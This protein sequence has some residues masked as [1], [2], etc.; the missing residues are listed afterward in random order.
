MPDKAK[1][2]KFIVL[3]AGGG[4]A[5]HVAPALAVGNWL[6]SNS[7]NIECEFIG[8]AMGMEKFMVPEAGFEL[9]EILKVSF[10]R[11][12]TLSTFIWPFRFIRSL[13]Q[14]RKAMLNADLL[15]G[16]GGYVCASSYVMACAKGIPFFVHEANALPGI[17]NRLGVRLGGIPLISFESTR[18]FGARWR[19]ASLVGI[20]LRKEITQLAAQTLTQRLEIRNR[21]AN[22]WGFN[23]DRPIVVVF[24]GSLGS[25]HINSV[26]QESKEAILRA[27]IQLVHAVGK[28]NELP[29]ASPGYQPVHYFN[30]MADVYASADLVISR[31]GAL[32]CHELGITKTYALLIPLA[33]GNGEQSHNG[34]SLVD[35][36]AAT[37]IFNSEFTSQWLSAH[38]LSLIASGKKLASSDAGD[39]GDAGD[40]D[41]LF[42]INASDVIGKMIESKLSASTLKGLK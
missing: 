31:S 7:A 5:G 28:D 3:L 37:M 30:D 11:G 10:P 39:V 34:Q 9:H 35:A 4:T 18:E 36:H 17:A 38:L 33:I 6:R 22:E 26:I 29:P 25:K 12:L 15:V 2:G 40:A 27:G 24:G 16:F 19:G 8:T 32:T 42:P 1:T 21:K 14:T 13:L 41:V 23:P 20:P